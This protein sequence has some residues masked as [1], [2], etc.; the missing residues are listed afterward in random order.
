M[1]HSQIQVPLFQ[2]NLSQASETPGHLLKHRLG[3]TLK[4]P[5]SVN[6]GGGPRIC[7]SDKLT[8]D[9]PPGATLKRTT[10]HG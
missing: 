9:A 3:S 4:A 7:V 6:L 1:T 5:D 2:S 10:A 8:G